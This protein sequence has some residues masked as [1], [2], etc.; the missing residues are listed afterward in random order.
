[1]GRVIHFEI[2]AEHPDRAIAFYSSLL[3]W[4]GYGK[5][6]EGNFF[7]MMQADPTAKM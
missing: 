6:T 1:M 2:H 7:G 5:D 3:G 4:L